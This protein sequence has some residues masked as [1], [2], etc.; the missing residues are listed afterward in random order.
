MTRSVAWIMVADD[1]SMKT[2]GSPS[3]FEGEFLT[4]SPFEEGRSVPIAFGMQ[5]N[6]PVGR[7]L[8]GGQKADP[9]AT[10]LAQAHWKL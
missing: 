4:S 9:A 7:P 3:I 2:N 1:C 10:P 8:R 6:A 5:R